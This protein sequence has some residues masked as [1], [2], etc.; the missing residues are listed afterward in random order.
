MV[1][2]V[3][4][5]LDSKEMGLGA[6]KESVLCLRYFVINHAFAMPTFMTDIARHVSKIMRE[7]LEG[8]QLPDCSSGNGV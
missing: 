4:V 2:E 6:S 8:F 5:V 1:K 7:D 3:L